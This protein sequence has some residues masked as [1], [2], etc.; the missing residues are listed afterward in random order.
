MTSAKPRVRT[1]VII[2]ALLLAGIIYYIADPMKSPFMPRCIFHTIT[3][4][5]CPGC[6]SQ[7]LI[8]A[9]LHADLAGAWRANALLLLML[10]YIL[11]LTAAELWPVR[12]PRLHNVL[13]ST[14][15]I[16]TVAAVIAGW[17]VLRNFVFPD[18]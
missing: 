9:L 16:I 10:P 3:G 2:G 12:L 5:Q 15:S 13:H 1:V 4:L 6:G 14:A 11:L 17:F 7:R 18:L 8:H